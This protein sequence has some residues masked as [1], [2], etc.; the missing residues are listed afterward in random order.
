MND[1]APVAVYIGLGSNLQNPKW[2]VESALAELAQLPETRMVSHSSLYRSRPVGPQDQDDF[3]NAVAHLTTRL[4]AESLLDALQRLEQQH[5]RVRERRWGPRSLDLDLLLFGD[6]TIDTP[7]LTVPH[8]EIAKRSFVLLPLHEIA[9]A[10]LMIPG[11]GLVQ[12]L[13]NGIERSD[14]EQLA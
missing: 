3:I 10:D 13:L 8:P 6:R 5:H 14:I 12:T 9:P 1:P 2:Q 7:R 4:A 11:L